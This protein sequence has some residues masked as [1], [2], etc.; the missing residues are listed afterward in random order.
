MKDYELIA[1]TSNGVKVINNSA[2]VNE[3]DAIACNL[4]GYAYLY[5]EM[6]RLEV[7]HK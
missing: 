3:L 5:G 7:R 6:C 4:E 1:L 2:D